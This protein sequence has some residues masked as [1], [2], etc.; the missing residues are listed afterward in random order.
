MCMFLFSYFFFHDDYH[1][2]TKGNVFN[3]ELP[4]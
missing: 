1:A 3:L 2:D 4:K